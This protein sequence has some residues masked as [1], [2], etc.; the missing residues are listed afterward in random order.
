[1]TKTIKVECGACGRKRNILLESIDGIYRVGEFYCDC[2]FVL[3]ATTIEEE[4][5]S[6]SENK[7][8][9]GG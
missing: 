9:E 8:T 1:M 7:K 6:G 2:S 4:A 5:E 3:M